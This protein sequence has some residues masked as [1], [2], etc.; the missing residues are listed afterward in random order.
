VRERN[1]DGS[2]ILADGEVVRLVVPSTALALGGRD[3][4]GSGTLFVTTE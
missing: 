3:P 2:P 4:V 1:A